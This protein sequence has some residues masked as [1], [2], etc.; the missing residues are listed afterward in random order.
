MS[1]P[2]CTL[3][4]QI[5]KYLHV[6]LNISYISKGHNMIHLINKHLYKYPKSHQVGGSYCLILITPE[7]AICFMCCCQIDV[8]KTNKGLFACVL[9]EGREHL[10]TNQWRFYR[11]ECNSASQNWQKKNKRKKNLL[12]SSLSIYSAVDKAWQFN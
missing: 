7:S 8:V 6:T 9:Y 10:M 5:P 4:S 2:A 12:K 11:N 3:N 1:T